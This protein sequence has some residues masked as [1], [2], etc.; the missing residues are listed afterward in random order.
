[1]KYQDA[2]SFRQALEEHLK[3]RAAQD[4]ARI[5]RDRKRIAFD[6]FLARLVAGARGEWLVKGGFALDLRMEGRARATKDVDLEWRGDADDLLDALLET[7]D[8]DAGD[9]FGF[10]IE[11]IGTSDDP[12][13]GTHRFRVTASLASRT[14]E[15]F[16]LDVEIRADS[17][18]VAEELAGDVLLDFAGIA[19]VV[20]TAVPIEI[21]V[22][23]K[24]HAYTRTYE[25][26]RKSTRTKDLV[27][28]ML[29]AEI[30]T[31]DAASLC[32]AIRATFDRRQ[33]HPIPSE[34]PAPPRTWETP[35]RTLAEAVGVSSDLDVGHRL[36]GELVD[37]IL[38][39]EVAA[40][41]W[42]PDSRQWVG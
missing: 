40:G 2:I 41:K 38:T 8:F 37:P 34:L 6:R 42:D 18:I 19:P 28:L 24:L 35:F 29:I 11:R 33:T 30:S 20:V 9:F 21:Q 26:G 12:F 25:G 13:G 39:G 27:D 23:E 14:F 5:Q 7:A 3:A 15:T 22:A 10:A 1:M 31:P 4:P 17:N 36:A 16:P 32:E